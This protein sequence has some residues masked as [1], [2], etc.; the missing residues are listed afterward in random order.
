VVMVFQS[1]ALYPHMTI[2]YNLS[3]GLQLAHRPKAEIDAKV[4]A[5]A[6]NPSHREL[7]DRKLAQLSGAATARGVGP[8]HGPRI[9]VRRAAFEPG[10]GPARR[11]AR[12]AHQIKPHR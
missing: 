1:Y 10:R 8:R 9:R 7:L 12:R 11:G 4:R 6:E 2:H 3:F 5:V